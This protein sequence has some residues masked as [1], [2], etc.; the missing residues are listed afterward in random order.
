MKYKAIKGVAHD[1]GHSFVSLT[2]YLADDYV[3][4]HLTRAA[5]V[6]GSAEL[7]VDLLTGDAE[8]AAL[9]VPPVRASLD[10]YTGW[11]PGMLR[12]QGVRMDF[13]REATM[14]VR[15]DLSRLHSPALSRVMVPLDCV[16]EITDDRGIV[17]VGTVREEWPLARVEATSRPP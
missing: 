3:M 1:F 16:V 11:L 13:V 10:I 9:L 7:R 6:S 8:P 15:I 4:E 5:A 2:N 12:E 17:H 14:S